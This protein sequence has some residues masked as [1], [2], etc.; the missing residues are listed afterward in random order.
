MAS[1]FLGSGFTP[2]GVRTWPIKA[3]PEHF[4]YS[5]SRLSFKF[6]SLHLSNSFSKL[7]SWCLTASSM[8]APRPEIRMSSAILYIPFSPSKFWSSFLWKYSGAGE[9]PKGIR[10]YRYRR[11]GVWNVINLLDSSS[12]CICKKP[13]LR[14]AF[15]NILTLVNSGSTS[16]M[17]GSG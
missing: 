10:K 16:S 4:S 5:F 6:R 17:T 3:V 9:I 15:E 1:T 2:S 13:S 12:N 11:Q 14:S 7:A 8:L